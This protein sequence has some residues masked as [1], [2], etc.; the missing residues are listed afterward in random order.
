MLPE[1]PF[2]FLATEFRLLFPFASSV[3]GR[4]SNSADAIAFCPS[5]FG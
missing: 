5:M 4:F 3:T 2:V 1:E